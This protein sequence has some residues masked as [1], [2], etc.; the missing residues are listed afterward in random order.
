MK[1]KSMLKIKRL[2]FD[3]FVV[4]PILKISKHLGW[5]DKTVSRKKIR[6]ALYYLSKQTKIQRATTFAPNF[7][8]AP[9]QARA[10]RAGSLHVN[11]A[12]GHPGPANQASPVNPAG[13]GSYIE[14]GSNNS[15]RIC[16][17]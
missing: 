6:T 16:R 10:S 5:L 2:G 9:M 4:L 7:G 17:I 13:P 15:W 14:S 11:R 8:L 3:R 12:E 1:T